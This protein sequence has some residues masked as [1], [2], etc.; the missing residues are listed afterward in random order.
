[1]I[2]SWIIS[3]KDSS[4]FVDRHCLISTVVSCIGTIVV[5]AGDVDIIL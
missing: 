4:F 1:M 2:L 5:A 3:I